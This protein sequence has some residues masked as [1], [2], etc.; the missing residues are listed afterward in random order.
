M[1]MTDPIA[2]LLTRIRNAQRARHAQ[3]EIPFS[4]VKAEI[5]RVLKDEGYL[6]DVRTLEDGAKQRLRVALRYTDD[7]RPMLTGIERVSKPGRRVYAGAGEIPPVLGGL[8]ICILSTSQ[9]V[10]SDREARRLHVGGELICN[11]W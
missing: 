10:M 2:D 6:D 7:G 11:V 9:G 4:G 3:T 8:G 5:A 1:S